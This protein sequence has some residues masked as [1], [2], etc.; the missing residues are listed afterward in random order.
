[1][2]EFIYKFKYVILCFIVFLIG[3]IVFLKRDRII[4]IDGV[5]GIFTYNGKWKY[6]RKFEKYNSK[7]FD[8]YS[9]TEYLG[10]YK[11]KYGSGWVVYSPDEIIP[12]EH[13]GT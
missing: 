1:M 7:K 2:Q 6:N 3:L 13:A 4:I 8:V 12:Y 9:G 5:N 11:M 10:N